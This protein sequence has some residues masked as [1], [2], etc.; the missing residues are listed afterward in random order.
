M[1]VAHVSFDGKALTDFI[2][3]KRAN[4]DRYLYV[5]HSPGQGVSVVNVSKPWMPTL[6]GSVA[7][8]DTATA[9]IMDVAGD[10]ILLTKGETGSAAGSPSAQPT[11]HPLVLWDT[12][13]ADGPRVI[14]QFANVIRELTD[15]RG[16]VYVLAADGLWVISTPTEHRQSELDGFDDFW[17]RVAY[18]NETRYSF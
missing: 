3:Q 11:V 12:S 17:V 5:E 14:K 4:G 13:R 7:W 9:H 15:D 6:V 10:A 16:Y 8:P 1:V 2:I 18:A